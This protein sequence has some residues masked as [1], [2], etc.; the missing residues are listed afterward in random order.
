MVFYT[1]VVQ[2]YLKNAKKIPF[3]RNN[4]EEKQNRATKMISVDEKATVFPMKLKLQGKLL[5]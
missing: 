2:F 4:L 5:E 1:L 3:W